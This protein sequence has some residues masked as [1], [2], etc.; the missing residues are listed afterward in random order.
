[1]KLY[2]IRHAQTDWNA[3]ARYVSWSDR[4]LSDEGVRQVEALRERFGGEKIDAVYS[5]PSKRALRTSCVLARTNGVEVLDELREIDFGDWEG[6]TYGEIDARYPIFREWVDSPSKT[7]IPGGEAWEDFIERVGRCADHIMNRPFESIAVVS[8]AGWLKA[9]LM[10]V[11]WIQKPVFSRLQLD[12]C[13]ITVVEIHGEN[14]RKSFTIVGVNDTSH[15][16]QA[17]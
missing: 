11:L 14:W 6:M 4:D 12:H 2:L 3:E 7:Q 15:L 9:M 17:P 13:G 10:S 16:Q 8:H 1:M 5:S